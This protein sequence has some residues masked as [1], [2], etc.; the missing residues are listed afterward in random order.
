MSKNT[1]F[2][3]FNSLKSDRERWQWVIDN[4]NL[5]IIVNLDN[6]DTFITVD[7][8]DEGLGR[9]DDYIGDSDGIFILL[10][11]LKIKAEYV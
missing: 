1:L 10:E 8:V 5:G 4:Q 7:D 9:F 3:K 6:D 11:V 2:N